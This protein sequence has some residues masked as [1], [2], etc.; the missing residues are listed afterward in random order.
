[1]VLSM[2][3]AAGRAEIEGISL[4]SQGSL[5]ARNNGNNFPVSGRKSVTANPRHQ[6]SRCKKLSGCLMKTAPSFGLKL[7]ET[8]ESDNLV[9]LQRERCSFGLK[10]CWRGRITTSL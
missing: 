8:P 10:A 2:T 9:A 3:A 6:T 1:M 5:L 4:F 7:R